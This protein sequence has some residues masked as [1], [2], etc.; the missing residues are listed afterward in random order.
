MQRWQMQ[1][2]A[3]A[4]NSRKAIYKRSDDA[5]AGAPQ[6][7]RAQNGVNIYLSIFLCFWYINLL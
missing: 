7:I 2:S 6:E 3:R 5:N 4:L 1:A